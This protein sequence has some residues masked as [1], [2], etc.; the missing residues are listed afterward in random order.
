MFGV[1]VILARHLNEVIAYFLASHTKDMIIHLE[2]ILTVLS[3]F[4]ENLITTT[5]RST[6]NDL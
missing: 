1:W 6:L 4:N 5:L 2:N 3:L